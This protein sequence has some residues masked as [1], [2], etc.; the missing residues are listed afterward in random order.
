VPD[1]LVPEFFRQLH[2]RTFEGRTVTGRTAIAG[3]L[4]SWK[5][6]LY[7]PTAFDVQL[8]DEATALVRGS[9]QYPRE[10]GHASGQVWWVDQI[11]DGLVWRAHG[12][13]SETAARAHHEQGFR[14]RIE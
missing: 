1:K 4:N 14:R 2:N 12:F 3:E 11:R 9:A 7:K 10:R 13:S 8:L 5:G 6:R